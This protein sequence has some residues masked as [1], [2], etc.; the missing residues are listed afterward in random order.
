MHRVA[1]KDNGSYEVI[2]SEGS[3]G[4]SNDARL[5]RNLNALAGASYRV[6]TFWNG[7]AYFATKVRM[8]GAPISAACEAHASFPHKCSSAANV[9]PESLP[10]SFWRS[11]L[12]IRRREA[13][14][15]SQGTRTVVDR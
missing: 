1:A 14:C 2:G 10:V 12:Q 13:P 15:S 7:T 4:A 5:R 8:A 6:K 11:N 3:D 9:E